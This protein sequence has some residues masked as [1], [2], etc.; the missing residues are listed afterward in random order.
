MTALYKTKTNKNKT[1]YLPLQIIGS[2]GKAIE[3]LPPR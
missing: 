3:C 2:E 1:Y